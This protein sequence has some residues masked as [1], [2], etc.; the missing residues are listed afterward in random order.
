MSCANAAKSRRGMPVI[1]CQLSVASYGSR[2]FHSMTR[3]VVAHAVESLVS[4]RFP[5]ELRPGR[6]WRIKCFMVVTRATLSL[7]ESG[8]E[9]RKSWRRPG[10]KV[11]V[12]QEDFAFGGED[13]T[14]GNWFRIPARGVVC[15]FSTC[16]HAL[17]QG[18]EVF[19]M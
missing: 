3:C 17:N 13:R 2:I 15:S 6:S 5:F 12:E 19:Q 14:A 11:F 1:S 16:R 18:Y 9:R 10:I 7:S 4:V 8:R